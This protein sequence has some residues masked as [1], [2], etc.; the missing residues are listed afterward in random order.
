MIERDYILRMI[1]QLIAVLAKIV[2]NIKINN[3]NQA[4][5]EINEAMKDMVNGDMEHLRDMSYEELISFMNRESPDYA[6]RCLVAAELFLEQARVDELSGEVVAVIEDTYVRALTCYIEGLEADPTMSK[7][8]LPRAAQA[9]AKVG[10]IDEHEQI[11]ALLARFEAV[12][13]GGAEAAHHRPATDV[14]YF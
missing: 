12:K 6:L 4:R 1:Q 14:G 9:A 5:H 7:R 3:P 13:S 10:T 11:P 8:F 2:F